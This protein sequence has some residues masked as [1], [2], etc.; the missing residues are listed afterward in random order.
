MEKITQEAYYSRY[1]VLSAYEEQ[2]AQ[3]AIA[4]ILVDG[5]VLIQL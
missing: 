1:R 2:S 3:N 4:G 5:G